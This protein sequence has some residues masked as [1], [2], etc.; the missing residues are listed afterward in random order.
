MLTIL[1]V[2]HA[3]KPGE[4]WPGPGL[5]ENGEQDTESLVIR[6]WARAG[7]WAALFGSGFGGADYPVPRAIYAAQPGGP[8]D[9]NQGPSRRPAETITTL[10]SR[11]VASEVLGKKWTRS[12]RRSTFAVQSI[13]ISAARA[14]TDE[15]GSVS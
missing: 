5:T 9:L 7:A 10:A 4:E 1:I 13:A 12:S 3:E 8:D 2:R 11:L 6:G 15:R 14:Q